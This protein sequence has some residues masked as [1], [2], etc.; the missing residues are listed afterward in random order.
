MLKVRMGRGRLRIS[1]FAA[2]NKNVHATIN[3]G[4]KMINNL[5]RSVDCNINVITLR[6]INR[7][8][9]LIYTFYIIYCSIFYLSVI[10]CAYKLNVYLYLEFEI[11]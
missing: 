5:D 1:N 3:C 8:V 7:L 11:Y 10:I 2:I 6:F 9:N 4:I